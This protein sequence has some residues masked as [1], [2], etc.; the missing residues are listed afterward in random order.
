MRTRLL[1][2]LLLLLPVGARAQL[3]LHP[4]E[5]RTVFPIGG[6]RGST[7]EVRAAGVNIGDASGVVVSGAGITAEV[8]GPDGSPLTL[9]APPEAR[10]V[11]N[12][13][14]RVRF[15]I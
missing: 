11:N 2:A 13:E 6:N 8:L 9:G 14:A 15:R 10:V 12:T 4:P 7:V 1:I 3:P 5:I